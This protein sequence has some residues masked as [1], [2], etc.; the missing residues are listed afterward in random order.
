MKKGKRFDCVEIMH[1]GERTSQSETDNL[2]LSE[3]LEY[4]KK[5]TISFKKHQLML[6]KN[7]G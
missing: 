3:R 5:K 1:K 2:T 6:R 7:V 4:W